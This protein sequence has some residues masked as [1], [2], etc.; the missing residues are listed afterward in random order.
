MIRP[1][2]NWPPP[3]ISPNSTLDRNA[4]EYAVCMIDYFFA[5]FENYPI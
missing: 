2:R 1:Y 4:V 3:L 5:S